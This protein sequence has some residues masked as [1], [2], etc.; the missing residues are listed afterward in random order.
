MDAQWHQLVEEVVVGMRY[1]R[2]AHPRATFREIETA[3]EGFS[4]G[5]LQ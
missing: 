3:V 4:P 1:W 5:L 2:A